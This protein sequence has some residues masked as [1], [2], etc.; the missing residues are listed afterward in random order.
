MTF[1]WSSYAFMEYEGMVPL[2]RKYKLAV[3][4]LWHCPGGKKELF[5]LSGEATVIREV[6]QE[7][8]VGPLKRSQMRYL[9]SRKEMVR[10][11]HHKHYYDVHYFQVFPT[12][13]QFGQIHEG[14]LEDRVEEVRLFA[15]NCLATMS[16]FSHS[17]YQAFK[18]QI[19][20]IPTLL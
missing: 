11:N 10:R 12:G 7:V 9:S 16:N 6:Y 5:E 18:D 14:F 3:P 13:E 15:R 4:G 20:G 2:V 19:V 1:D 8:G 17:H